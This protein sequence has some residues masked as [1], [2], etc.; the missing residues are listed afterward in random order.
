VL[1]ITLTDEAKDEIRALGSNAQ[2][3][4]GA[5][6]SYVEQLEWEEAL[7]LTIVKDLG[8]LEPGIFEIIVKGKGESYRAFCFATRIRRDAWSSSPPRWR[9]RPCWGMPG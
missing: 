7:R 9:S 8:T 6:I 2:A 3:R 4:I 5:K 1:R